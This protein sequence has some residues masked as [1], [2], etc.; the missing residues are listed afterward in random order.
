MPGTPTDEVE[1]EDAT[2]RT[3]PFTAFPSLARSSRHGAG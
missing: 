1:A 3:L 2:G